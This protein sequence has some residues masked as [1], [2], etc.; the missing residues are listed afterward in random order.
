ME[1]IKSIESNFQKKNQKKIN[2]SKNRRRKKILFA[3]DDDDLQ[4]ITIGPENMCRKRK[5]KFNSIDNTSQVLQNNFF[6]KHPSTF[7][8]KKEKNNNNKNEKEVTEY[9]TKLYDEPHLTKSLFR[10]K[11]TKIRNPNRKVSFLNPINSKSK[12]NVNILSINHSLFKKN[13]E[14]LDFN[15][16]RIF[17]D[18]DILE[19][20]SQEYNKGN[21][22]YFMDSND[23][24][25]KSEIITGKKHFNTRT[26][27]RK[28]T[29]KTNKTNNKKLFNLYKIRNPDKKNTSNVNNAFYN[30][31]KK[32]ISSKSNNKRSRKKENKTSKDKN[33]KDKNYEKIININNNIHINNSV[34]KSNN[35]IR[36]DDNEITK[37][38]KKK[39]DADD[40]ETAMQKEQKEKNDK[41]KKK[42]F[43]CFPFLVCL[44]LKND[45]ENE[46]IL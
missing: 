38:C 19:E 40:I 1:N 29:S 2:S 15:K 34:E 31:T 24:M 9:L 33:N 13:S 45:E 12:K 21:G 46:N 3:K 28:Q 30:I 36:N 27:R 39:Q 25:L 5:I 17:N 35:K 20:Q 6:D 7:V 41:K 18:D 37:K 11:T 10:K 42:Q 43:C 23:L 26:I 14:N 32:H 16:S 4:E 8:G 22:L 44:K